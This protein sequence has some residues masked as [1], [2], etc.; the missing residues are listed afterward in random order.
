MKVRRQRKRNKLGDRYYK[1]CSVIIY[2]STGVF[3]M[4][5]NANAR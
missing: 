1:S 3:A 5:Q 2:G 4:V